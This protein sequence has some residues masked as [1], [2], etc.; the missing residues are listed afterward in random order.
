MS[1]MDNTCPS[2]DSYDSVYILQV[3][4]ITPCFGLKSLQLCYSLF[5]SQ[6][7]HFDLWNVDSRMFSEPKFMEIR[8]ITGRVCL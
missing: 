3:I 4:F 7:K 2:L 6:V 5:A 8:A 1:A